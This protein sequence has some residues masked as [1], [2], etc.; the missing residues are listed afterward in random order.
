MDDFT[1]EELKAIVFEIYAA[2][3]E[4]GHAQNI[5][6]QTAYNKFWNE[7]AGDNKNAKRTY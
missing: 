3:F 5:D 1:P 7:M 2:G 6:I 4:A